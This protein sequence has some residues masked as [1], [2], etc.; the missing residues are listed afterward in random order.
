MQILNER[1]LLDGT[2]VVL[3]EKDFKKDNGSLGSWRY[4]ERK[5]ARQA[6]VIVPH[7]EKTDS[8]VL[9]EQF[10]M[11]F[12]ANVIEFPAGLVDDGETMDRAAE[13]EL[14]EE[15]GFTGRVLSI[16]PDIASS[17]GLTSE[18][19]RLIYMETPETADTEPQLEGAEELQV[20][21]IP[22]E[23]MVSFYYNC[24]KRGIIMDAKVFTYIREHYDIGI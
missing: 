5:Q 10:R 22:P 14:K 9:I 13:R 8:L 3:K 24:I 23:N 6:A 19:I 12:S 1:I 17:S 21:V 4:I 15:T 20:H 2:W 18:T 7:T 11:P 16:S